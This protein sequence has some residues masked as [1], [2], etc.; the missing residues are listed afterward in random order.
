[1]AGP[2]HFQGSD[3]TRCPRCGAAIDTK[4]HKVGQADDADIY[5][6]MGF[7]QVRVRCPSCKTQMDVIEK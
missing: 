1:M 5:R 7:K 2:I 3:P 6:A 4:R